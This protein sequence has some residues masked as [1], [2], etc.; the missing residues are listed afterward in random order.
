MLD[1]PT[2]ECKRVIINKAPCLV[3][4]CL[5][6]WKYGSVWGTDDV[7]SDFYKKRPKKAK[8]IKHVHG[9]VGPNKGDGDGHRV[10]HCYETSPLKQKG[11]YLVEVG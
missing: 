8:P 2:I 5:H 7:A 11:Y 9:A 1:I 6:C 3:F 10:A 4:E